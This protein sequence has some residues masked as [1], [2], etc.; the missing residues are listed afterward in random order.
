[1]IA[2]E[3]LSHFSSFTI[4]PIGIILIFLQILVKCR[5]K[6]K[7]TIVGTYYITISINGILKLVIKMIM[8][9]FVFSLYRIRLP[10]TLRQMVEVMFFSIRK[11]PIVNQIQKHFKPRINFLSKNIKQNIVIITYL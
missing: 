1:M 5:K 10:R 8:T 7:E 2:N 9:N 4:I 6:F 11:Y 3:K